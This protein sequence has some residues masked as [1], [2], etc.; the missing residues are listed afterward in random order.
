MKLTITHLHTLTRGAIRPA[1]SSKYGTVGVRSA[2][3]MRGMGGG[4]EAGGCWEVVGGIMGKP[5]GG[6]LRSGSWKDGP[7]W[8]WL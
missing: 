3:L 6:L 2:S 1:G 8:P 7:V 5:G 4:L